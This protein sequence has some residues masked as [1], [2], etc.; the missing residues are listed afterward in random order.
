MIALV[1]ALAAAPAA[2]AAGPLA[3]TAPRRANA[4]T[5]TVRVV[6][7]SPG[8]G[9]VSY[10]LTLR[11]ASG[12]ACLVS[13]APGLRLLDAR[14]RPLPTVVAPPAPGAGTAAELTVLPGGSL[15]VDARFSPDVP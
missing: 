2:A 4:L 7:G 8:A 15:V 9:S 12:S 14:G 5:G 11:N 13:G 3:V 6:P 1:A 10:R